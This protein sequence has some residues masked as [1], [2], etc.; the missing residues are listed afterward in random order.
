MVSTVIGS[1]AGTSERLPNAYRPSYTGGTFYNIAPYANASDW[2][3]W[4]PVVNYWKNGPSSTGYLT[5]VNSKFQVNPTWAGRNATC[6]FRLPTQMGS[7]RILVGLGDG[8]VRTV[9]PGVS[10]ATW[11]SAMT[12]TG[13]EV[14]G[15]DWN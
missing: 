14:L 15:S 9:S 13:G 12:A 11:W 6:D 10:P 4:M 3:E 7:G 2:Y 5:G 1:G 8:S